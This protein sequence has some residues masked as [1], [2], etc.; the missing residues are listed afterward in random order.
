MQKMKSFREYINESAEQIC[1]Y[2]AP[3]YVK[4][5]PKKDAK[6]LPLLTVAKP[7]D[8]K[9]AKEKLQAWWIRIN[10]DNPEAKNEAKGF[11]KEV[12]FANA[13]LAL[14]LGW[15]LGTAVGMDYRKF[16]GDAGWKAA[17]EKVEARIAELYGVPVQAVQQAQER[18]GMPEGVF[19]DARQAS[20]DLAWKL[21]TVEQFRF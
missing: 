20:K 17:I 21:N 12:T 9:G 19:V 5:A 11:R 3:E 10:P 15:M 4:G 1:E 7:K 16:G 13:A 8:P 6:G 2:K 14:D 18:K